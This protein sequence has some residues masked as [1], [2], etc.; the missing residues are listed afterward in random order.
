LEAAARVILEGKPVH[1][2]VLD[3]EWAP[4]A[5]TTPVLEF[6]P[7]SYCDDGSFIGDGAEAS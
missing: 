2:S 3:L 4:G 6:I 7:L 1:A 5:G